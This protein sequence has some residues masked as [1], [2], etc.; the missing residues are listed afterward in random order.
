MG[1]NAVFVW[2]EQVMCPNVADNTLENFWGHRD[3]VGP[4]RFIINDLSKFTS[5]PTQLPN[6]AG[7]GGRR[8][9]RRGGEGGGGG[10]L[11]LF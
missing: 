4:T 10:G 8:G 6:P 11:G 9:M 1:T 5:M 7:G 2:I 3:P